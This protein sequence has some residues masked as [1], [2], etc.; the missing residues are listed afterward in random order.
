M[1]GTIVPIINPQNNENTSGF[2][3]ISFVGQMDSM[4]IATMIIKSADNAR[5]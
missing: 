3:F 4:C 2:S 1:K 5:T